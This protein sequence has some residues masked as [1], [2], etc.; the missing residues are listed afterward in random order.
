V[1]PAGGQAT[2]ATLVH[3]ALT[4]PY[5]PHD[6][7]GYECAAVVLGNDPKAI[8]GTAASY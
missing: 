4:S 5:G 3:R 2:P 6:L 8:L 7:A 1:P